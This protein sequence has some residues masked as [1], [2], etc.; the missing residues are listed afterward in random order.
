M[1]R[2][3]KTLLITLTVL[4][5]G[6]L[7]YGQLEDISHIIPSHVVQ[8]EKMGNRFVLTGRSDAYLFDDAPEGVAVLLDGSM[9]EMEVLFRF[10]DAEGNLTEWVQGKSVSLPNSERSVIYIRDETCQTSVTFEYKV[11]SQVGFPE[12]I[13]AGIFLPDLEEYPEGDVTRKQAITD[14][15]KPVII[16]RSEWGARP[17]T[18]GYSPHP[19]YI[20]LTLHHAAGFSANNIDEGI[21]QLRAIQDLHQYVRGWSDIG[22]HFVVDKAGNI[23]QGRPET[24]IG[25][26][27]LNNNTGNIGVCVLGCYHPPELYCGD[28]L[29]E[30]TTNSLVA[31]YAWISGEYNYDPNVLLGHRDYI[32]NYTSCPGNN[33]HERLPWF[34]NEIER[35]MDVGGPPLEFTISRNYPNP[36]NSTTQIDYQVPEDNHIRIVV[37]DLMGREVRTLMDKVQSKGYY[38]IE[39]N[40]ESDH[41]EFVSTGVYFF[42]FTSNGFS[43][44]KKMIFLK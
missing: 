7:L 14:L 43:N 19:Y 27:V 31:L 16:S 23:Y 24:V 21:E 4:L 18:H 11:I 2:T 8:A 44:E 40:G 6:G 35:Y 33:V 12:I 41:G 38:N 9:M 26:H 1:S 37:Y 10:L 32:E 42:Q 36:F 3:N 5:A 28:W 30:A 29:T 15:P 20:K 25:A 17:P 13:S 22:Y 34:R 39:W